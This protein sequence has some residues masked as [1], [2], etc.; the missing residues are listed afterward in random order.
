MKNLKFL[1]FVTLVILSTTIQSCLNYDHPSDEFSLTEVTTDDKIYHGAADKIDFS[2]LPTQEGFDKAAENLKSMF[3]QSL[4]AQYAMRGGKDG[5]P[6]LAHAYQYQFCL[7]TDCY[8]QYFVVPHFDFYGGKT[9]TSTYNINRDFNSGP[10]GQF[11]IVK[12]ALSPLLNHPDIDSIPELKAIY[13]LLLDYSSQEVADIYGP[14]PYTDFKANKLEP[15]FKFDD[16]RT[17]YVNIEA[18]LDS[19][20]HCLRNF[21]SR[22]DWYQSKVQQLMNSYLKVTKTM[23]GMAKGMETYIRFANSLKLRM[24]MHIAKV[25]EKLARKWAEEAVRDGVIESVDNEVA[26]N[27]IANGVDNPLVTI[28]NTWHDV[29]LNASF[30]S[31]LKSLDH[32]YMQYLFAKNNAPIVNTTT[33]EE[34][35]PNTMIVGMRAGVRPGESQNWPLNPYIAYSRLDKEA[36]TFAPL[37]LMKVSEVDFLRAEGAVRGWNMGGNAEQFYRHGIEYGYLGDRF[38]DPFNVN[39]K[40]TDHIQAYLEQEKATDYIYKDPQGITPDMP[41]V[42]KIGVKWNDG[43][44]KELKLEKIITQKYIA[45][46]P[47]SFEAWTDMRRTGYPKIFPVLNVDDGD[48]SLTSEG[49]L[50]LIRRMIFPG[51]DDSY[52]KDVQTTGLKA[53]GGADKQATRLWWDVDAPNF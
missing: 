22:P 9:M 48:G 19:I 50:N 52:I 7:T 3:K 5:R 6:P 31:I 10:N 49:P 4:T 43:D 39:K 8:A 34:T 23:K 47:Y 35:K 14:F 26:I 51:S 44:S 25:D 16:M 45:L 32:P 41:S 20:V 38:M 37:Y 13:L 15:P 12:N 36:I 17:I 29:V 21:S 30:E 11:G 33:K 24:A 2:K 1:S 18:N 46:F 28:V 53:L 40:Y 42:T 27:P